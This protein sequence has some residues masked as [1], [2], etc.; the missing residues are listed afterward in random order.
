MLEVGWSE[1]LVIAILLIVFV[2]P[3]DLPPMLR[4]FGKF[5]TQLR[6]MAGQFQSQFN[7]ALKDA[8]LDEVRKTIGDVQRLNPANT[9]RDAMSPLRQIGA[10]LK[11]DLQKSVTV[12]KP[13]TAVTPAVAVEE[14]AAPASLPVIETPPPVIVAPAA[15]E[16]AIV[17]P[18]PKAPAKPRAKAKPKDAP[19]A[20][21]E[22]AADAERPKKKRA[23]KAAKD[24]GAE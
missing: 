16:T 21:Q 18:K 11:A 7:E 9:I 1:L 17:A 6:T 14:A 22:T 20:I 8:D 4:A 2:G 24:T 10:D 5:M 13:A 19:V 3:K 15:V 23:T 12:E